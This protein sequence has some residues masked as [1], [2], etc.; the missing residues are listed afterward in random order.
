MET[1]FLN[2][3]LGLSL[4]VLHLGL[5]G[6]LRAGTPSN[7]STNAATPGLVHSVAT[8]EVRSM[9]NS[10]TSNSYSSETLTPSQRNL[11]LRHAAETHAATAGNFG[12]DQT[13]S[14]TETSSGS[15]ETANPLSTEPLT[16]N[17]VTATEASSSSSNSRDWKD[18]SSS[19][20]SSRDWKDSSSSSRTSSSRDWKDSRQ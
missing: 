17:F 4:L 14:I 3:V 1:W 9:E 11:L 16:S 12:T 5:P 10:A 6:P 13:Q 15:I 7:N 18:S 8:D 20:S 2:H 19:S